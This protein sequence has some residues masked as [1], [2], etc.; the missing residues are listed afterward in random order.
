MSK[1]LLG[2]GNPSM[3]DDSVG[4]RLAEEF[5]DQA[6]NGFEAVD[7]A[8]DSMRM[9]FYC[10]P[11]TEQIIVVDCVDMGLE[12][13]AFRVF[14][15]EDVESQKEIGNMSTH[16][17][18]VLKVIELGRQL[19]YHVPPVKIFGVQPENTCF[20]F[21]LSPALQENYDVYVQELKSIMIG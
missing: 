3:A 6:P 1:Y 5:F 4:L 7:M 2:L 20:G 15:P 11:G 17:G 19:G 12:P 14:A 18:D 16:E 8:H 9:L 10:E 13:G 21:D